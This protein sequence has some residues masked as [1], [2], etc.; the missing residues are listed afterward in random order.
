MF[1]LQ[2]VYS[3]EQL[4]EHLQVP[5]DFIHKEIDSGRLKA[6][7][8]AGT[9][10]ITFSSFN[11]FIS[12]AAVKPQDD[13]TIQRS[14][15]ADWLR[16]EPAEDFIQ[17]WPDGKVE[18]YTDAQEGIAKF[19]GRERHVKL[20]KS[21]RDA[22]GKLRVRY[23]VLIDR[24]ATVEF[25]GEDEKNESGRIASVIK[26]RDGKQIPPG[27]T[28][29]PE[30]EGLPLGFYREVVD[31]PGAPNGLAVVCDES[32]VASMVKHALIRSQYRAERE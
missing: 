13:S 20:G 29:P 3:P 6:F 22:A 11:S 24:Y 31:G 23:V 28:P 25:A 26:G 32:D 8:V 17:N 27:A 9:R 7:E 19:G 15:S 2:Q 21:Q 18:T 5:V 16:L 30:Y 4:A 12:T 14:S 10:R 1:E